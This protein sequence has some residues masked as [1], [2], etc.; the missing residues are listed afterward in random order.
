MYSAALAASFA[1]NLLAG[2]SPTVSLA[3]AVPSGAEGLVGEVGLVRADGRVLRVSL[4][5]SPVQDRERQPVELVAQLQDLGEKDQ[6][7]EE[8]RRLTDNDPLTG[9]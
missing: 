2:H 7:R 9:L 1:S 6:T 8:L 3:F 4:G 5:I